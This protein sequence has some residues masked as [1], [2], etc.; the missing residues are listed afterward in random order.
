MGTSSAGQDWPWAEENAPL[1]GE[2]R[3]W[4]G[5]LP[6]RSNHAGGRITRN[7]EIKEDDSDD[8]L[9]ILN[10]RS[11]DEINKKYEE[12]ESWEEKEA[13]SRTITDDE[14]VETSLWW[15]KD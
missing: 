7:Q 14:H 4:P 15:R 11:S 13:Q 10:N 3:P 8:N 6:A 5:K 12:E 2:Y 9:D 1:Q